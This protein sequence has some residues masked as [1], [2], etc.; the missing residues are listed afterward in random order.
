MAESPLGGISESASGDALT[1]N[2]PGG[3]IGKASKISVSSHLLFDFS[4]F[5]VNRFPRKSPPFYVYPFETI[6]T[7]VIVSRY[8]GESVQ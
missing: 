7:R 1:H 8:L 4:G 3:D 6:Y 2:Q 5:C